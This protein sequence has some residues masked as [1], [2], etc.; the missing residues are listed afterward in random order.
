MLMDQSTFL[1]SAGAPV[2]P[3]AGLGGACLLALALLSPAPALGQLVD[4]GVFR[5]YLDGREA[6]TEEFTI[7]RRGTGGAQETLAMGTV[8]MRSGRVFKTL[9]QVQGPGMVL[10]EYQVS[11]TG[12][13]TAEVRLVRAGNRLRRTVVA[14]D[15]ERVREFRTRPETAIFEDGVAHHYFVLGAFLEG[16][17]AGATLHTFTPLADEPE[18]AAL[19]HAG[20][21]LIESEGATVETTQVRLGSGEDA[22]AAWFDGSGR[23]VRV[24]LPARGFLA[25]RVP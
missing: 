1:S 9:L 25:V 3:S 16:D 19:L 6:G 5:L 24:S 14:P 2:R 23:L 17:I 7:H 22:G 4:S 21:E 10:A 20:P 13:D 12:V 15:G 18:S 8:T 11:V